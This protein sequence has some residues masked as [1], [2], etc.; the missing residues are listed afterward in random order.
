[1][2]I[3]D[4]PILTLSDQDVWTV[5]NAVEGVQIFGGIGSGKTSGSGR[6]LALKYLSAGYGGL[7]L[8]VKPD[9]RQLWEDY[10]KVA[11]REKDLLV[12]APDSYPWFNFLSY[13]SSRGDT[14]GGITENIV[15]VLR[16]VMKASA[17]QGKSEDPFWDVAL[18]MLL[19]HL[20]ELCQ[21]AKQDVTVRNLYDL[22]QS[23]PKDREQFSSEEWRNQAVFGQMWQ[24]I[25]NRA[26]HFKKDKESPD[27]Y[28]WDMV[29]PFFVNHF[30]DL[31]EKTRSII[32][33]SLIGFL[34]RLVRDPV[35]T[36]FC[37]NA[38]TVLPEDCYTEGKIILIDFPVKVFDKV[39]RDVQILFK[40]IWQRAMERRDVSKDGGRPVFLWADEAQNFLH[41]HDIDYQ[42]TA[43]SSRVCTVYITQN[44]PNYLAHLGG[45]HGKYRVQ[46]FLGTLGTKIFH[47]NA[48]VETN[49]YASKLIGQGYKEKQSSSKSFSENMSITEGKSEALEYLV[50]PEKF[51]ALRT[52]GPGYDFWVSAIAHKQGMPWN[53]TK[54]N[55]R[56]MEFNQNYKSHGN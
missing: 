4:E 40:Y 29:E 50:R 16:T 24:R 14:G 42:A 21:L 38:S 27:K 34:F 56:G 53:A 12:L 41:E 37:K 1:M 33:Y 51:V 52:G 7:V 19:F 8:T 17:S 32:E 2:E 11:G 9:E 23:L 30:I 36:S 26:E 48:D 10:C 45:E 43:R 46:S 6:M 54:R 35:Y 3:L 39:G 49:E 25:E 20:V 5:R 55:H 15:Q 44:L 18:D 47:A 22:A 31:S 28:T 13:E